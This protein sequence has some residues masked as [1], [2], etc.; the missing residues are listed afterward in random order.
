MGF[1]IVGFEVNDRINYDTDI[2]TTD[3]NGIAVS[4]LNNQVGVAV[5]LIKTEKFVENID[6][7]EEESNLIK[8]IKD[9]MKYGK[10]TWSICKV[11]FKCSDVV[12]QLVIDC[13]IAYYIKYIHLLRNSVVI[14]AE[15]AN[16]D[17][18]YI[19]MISCLLE[20]TENSDNKS[21]IMTEGFGSNYT[22]KE[23]E[24][25]VVNIIKSVLAYT[26]SK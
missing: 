22:A 6:I 26:Y 1:L 4:I 12:N 8:S 24:I 10:F 15:Q 3:R 17:M 2:V 25:K 14:S 5:K 21:R 23:L 19:L 11:D 20:D 9:I 13:L 16:K 18:A 7:L